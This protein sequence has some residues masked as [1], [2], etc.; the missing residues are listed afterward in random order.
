VESRAGRYRFGSFV[1]DLG[2]GELHREGLRVHLQEQPFRVLEV[3]LA[4]PGELVTRD[5]LRRRLWPADT[6]VA[7]DAG[8]NN[9]VRRLREALGDT[10]DAP[11]FVETIAKRGYRFLAPVERTEPPGVEA[12]RRQRLALL[13]ALL[14]GAGAALLLRPGAPAPRGKV[15][16]AVLP[17]AN[18]DADESQDY[19]SDGLTDEMIARLGALQPEGLGVIARTSALQ[20]KRTS[21]RAD[22]IGRELG[23]SYL[24]EGSVRRAGGRV[25]ISA[26]LIQLSDQTPLLSREYDGELRDM[27]S[28]QKAV[29]RSVAED[30]RLHLSREALSRLASAKPVD[31][32]AYEQYLRGR[33]AWSQ[34]RAAG[35][36]EA[37][38]H[39][40]R[41]IAR[42]PAYAPA[43][44]GLA[45]TYSLLSFYGG[46]PPR[47]VFP[48]ARS[49]A[50]RAI[51]LDPQQAE[52]H[53]SLAYVL[54]RFDWEWAQAEQAYRHALQLNPS[55]ATAHHW[56][57][58]LLMV[59]GRMAESR[60]EMRAA[61]QLD[62]LSPRINLD[63]GLP[64]YFEDDQD[65]AIEV[66]R[67][68]ADLHPG[69]VPAQIAL[70]QACERKG[71]FREAA[72]ALEQ[73]AEGLG[74]EKGPA[75]DVRKA[76]ESAGAVGY[77][78][79]LLGQVERGWP[80]PESPAHRANMW[81]ALGD[82]EQALVWLERAYAE[83][84]DE[85]VWIAVEPWYEP[86]RAEPRFTAL[87]A[88]MGLRP[89]PRARRP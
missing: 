88:R 78:R 75:K 19:F 26:R 6:F 28:L 66:A 34:R 32:A 50:E 82:R 11:R 27:L 12:P 71:L 14:I 76:A 52:A 9:A 70:R 49:A 42:D 73:T 5:E 20:Y 56:Y 24:L 67:R 84:D 83:R 69:F 16:L 25:R 53:T 48:K 38:G 8:L 61:Q 81:A 51:V 64:H 30:I 85:L 2:T 72:Q 37:L 58:E 43:H 22:Q 54:H 4:R 33:F 10:A 18:L 36:R 59:T 31:P 3:L 74:V 87:L 47:E 65:A 44:A 41:A 17:F 15:M 21:K 45:D 57:A 62:P 60:Q 89:A 39:F 23:V 7:F 40:E 55:Y 29:A 63:V 68:V 13:A 80:L 46:L 1:A 35:L 86:L 79:A 77:W